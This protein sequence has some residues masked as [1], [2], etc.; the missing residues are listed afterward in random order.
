MKD[1]RK[2]KEKKK[3]SVKKTFFMDLYAKHHRI[4]P[5]LPYTHH[6]LTDG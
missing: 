5:G 2:K 1:S 4:K 6:K 3:K